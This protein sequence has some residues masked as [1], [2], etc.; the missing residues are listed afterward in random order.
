MKEQKEY[1]HIEGNL[2]EKTMKVGDYVPYLN[3]KN[4]WIPKF[5]II[6]YFVDG[7]TYYTL[8]NKNGETL[9]R[10]PAICV[11][12][13]RIVHCVCN[14]YDDLK[15]AA[16]RGYKQGWAYYQWKRR[17]EHHRFWDNFRG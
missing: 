3:N 6:S 10:V 16:R 12:P 1:V 9:T 5:K 17:Q 15:L 14:T 2:E 7:D 13:S 11:R 4:K 8:R